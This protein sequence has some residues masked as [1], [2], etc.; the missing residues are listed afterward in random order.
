LNRASF[1]ATIAS[2][3]HRNA[4]APAPSRPRHPV[5]PVF[6]WMLIAA[7]LIGGLPL[8]TGIVV[9]A[10]SKP[11]FTLD[12]CHPIGGVSSNLSQS[13]APLIP[14]HAAAQPP[15]ESGVAH[16]FVFVLPPGRNQAPDPPP[17]EIA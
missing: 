10:D 4:I 9:V 2:V 11:A 5:S 17:P 3:Q 16:D 7:I 1:N 12:V 15:A 13:E 6:A 8:V 14:M